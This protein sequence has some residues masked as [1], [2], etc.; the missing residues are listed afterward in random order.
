L[1]EA[2][3]AL[4]VGS[5]NLVSADDDAIFADLRLSLNEAILVVINLGKTLHTDYTLKLK[6]STLAAGSY[7]ALPLFGTD[8]A[9]NLQVNDSGGFAGYM[10]ADLPPYSTITLQLQPSP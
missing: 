1:R 6:S 7:T 9:A 5:L 3:P 4:R 8:S 10:P 2:H